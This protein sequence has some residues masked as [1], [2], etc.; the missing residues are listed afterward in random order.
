MNTDDNRRRARVGYI[1]AG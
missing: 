1:I